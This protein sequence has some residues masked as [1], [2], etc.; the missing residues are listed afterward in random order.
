M[1]LISIL[2]TFADCCLPLALT[3]A[4]SQLHDLENEWIT[5]GR[6]SLMFLGHPQVGENI[7]PDNQGTL[8][9]LAGSDMP[10]QT[11]YIDQGMFS[12]VNLL[13]PIIWKFA[14]ERDI[15]KDQKS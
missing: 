14:R 4:Q 6:I 12:H 5:A 13:M 1:P 11:W 9:K 7:G 10:R 15:T 2:D 8:G 3:T